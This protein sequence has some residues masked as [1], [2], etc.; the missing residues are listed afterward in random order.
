M[1]QLVQARH[2]LVQSAEQA[3]SLQKQIIEGADFS[4]LAQTNSLCPSKVNGGDLGD[5]GRGM[6]VKSFE[7]AAFGLEVGAVSEPVQTQF[8]WHIIKR[9][10]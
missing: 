2:I 5:F 1:N 9:T 10:A 3:Q 4:T 7:D 6:M 8:G